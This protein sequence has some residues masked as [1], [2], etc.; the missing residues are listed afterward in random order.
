VSGLLSGRELFE[1]IKKLIEQAE[2]VYVLTQNFGAL[3]GTTLEIVS[4]LIDKRRSGKNVVVVMRNVLE[5]RFALMNYKV[6]RVLLQ[7][8]IDVYVNPEIHT[9]MIL[10]DCGVYL[11]SANI[12]S[13]LQSKYEVGVIITEPDK[14]RNYIVYVNSILADKKTIRANLSNL[15][16]VFGIQPEK[17]VKVSE[18]KSPLDERLFILF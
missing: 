13:R 4:L 1:K 14:L 11:G 16:S 7:N 15:E 5:Y 10:T 17:K 3:K 9:K 6:A 12:S 18:E 2:F 8:N